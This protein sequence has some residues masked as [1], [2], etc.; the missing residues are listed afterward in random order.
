M[1]DVINISRRSEIV[2]SVVDD[3]GTTK[4]LRIVPEFPKD[5]KSSE[6]ILKI[7][8][9]DS[10]LLT[11]ETIANQVAEAVTKV[12][13]DG[14]SINLSDYYKKSEVDNK[15]TNEVFGNIYTKVQ[16]D[17]MLLL[18]V[19]KSLLENNYTNNTNY[20]FTI[21]SSLNADTV[22]EDGEIIIATCFNGKYGSA[23]YQPGYA[24]SGIKNA[25][26]Y[27]NYLLCNGT[28]NWYQYKLVAGAIGIDGLIIIP[29][30]N[31][32]GS[33]RMNYHNII[34]LYDENDKLY[35]TIENE[36]SGTSLS[37]FVQWR[38]FYFDLFAN[39]TSRIN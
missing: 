27:A 12:L 10:L 14:S 16:T 19:D 24:F 15:L 5:N 36:I 3:D 25:R 39:I 8:F 6:V 21:N 13:G 38:S 30:A 37:S 11:S 17:G 1:Q 22:V 29:L 28:D 9:A 2:L 26:A 23:E 34:D 33:S 7:P 32:H 18:K 35:T 31:H 4:T 20:I